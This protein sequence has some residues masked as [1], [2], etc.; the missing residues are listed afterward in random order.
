LTTDVEFCLLG[1]LV[2]RQGGVPV[3]ILPAKLR[4]LLAT[5]L[6][7]ANQPVSLDELAEAMWGSAPPRSS[8]GTLRNHVKSLRKALPEPLSSRIRTQPGGYLFRVQAGELDIDRFYELLSS[9]KADTVNG[10]F[11]RA[12]DQL[13]RCLA[14]WRGEPLA[15]V[16][17]DVLTLRELPRLTEMRL[18]ALAARIDADLQLGKHSDVIGEL[19][20]LTVVHPLRER[21]HALLM[22]ALYRDGQQA[23]ALAAYQNARRV[24]VDELA[25]EP[26]P[27]LRRL[28]RQI[29]AADP[30]LN[31]PALSRRRDLTHHEPRHQ[32][33]RTRPA[34]PRELPAAVRHFTGRRR[35][36]IALTRMSGIAAPSAGGGAMIS[37][38]SG[39]AGVGKTALAVHW[40]HMAAG[41]FP[42]GQ[43]FANLRGYNPTGP[44]SAAEA[45]VGFL[46][47]LGVPGQNIPTELDELAGQFRS[48]VADRR[49]LVVLDNAASV[50]QV[51][52]LLPGGTG[53]VAVITSR[54]SLPGLVAADGAQR[55]N[56][57]PLPL[58]DA[59]QILRALVGDRVID[60]PRAAET[61]A[62]Q[63]ARLPLALRLTA[64]LAAAQPGRR[65]ADLAADLA[66][67][68][69]RLD[70]LNAGGDSR[71]GLRAVF[72]SS[73]QSLDEQTA[74]A[75]RLIGLLPGPDFDAYALA[76]LTG[77]QLDAAQSMLDQL[78]G[79]CLVHPTSHGRFAMHDLLHAYARGLAGIA[80]LAGDSRPDS[81]L[82]RRAAMAALFDYY[83]Y[84]AAVASDALFPS[85]AG[86]RPRVT[87]PASSVPPIAA[88][89]E[90]R[91]WLDAERANLAAAA[92]QMADDGWHSHVTRLAAVLA[93]YLDVGGYYQEA[94]AIHGHASR[95]ASLAGDMSAE[96]DSARNLGIV[97]FRQGRYQRAACFLQRALSLFQALGDVARE[98]RALHDLSLIDL[99][100]GRRYAQATAQLER[101]LSLFRQVGDQSGQARALGNLGLID[102]RQGRYERA[103]HYLREAL[104]LCRSIG[105]R[106]GQARALSNLGVIEERQGRWASA[107]GYLRDALTACREIGDRAGEADILRSLGMIDSR[108]GD[109]VSA[110]RH[111]QHALALST[112]IGERRCQ[113]WALTGLG[114]VNLRQGQLP[115]AIG[116]LQ[117]A[118]ELYR[119]TGN[120]SGEA[121]ACNGLG[122]VLLASGEPEDASLQHLAALSRAE[123]TGE[124]DELARAHYGVARCYREIGKLDQARCHLRQ[125]V[126]KFRDLGAPEVDAARGLLAQLDQDLDQDLDVGPTGTRAA[127]LAASPSLA[128]TSSC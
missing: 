118:L 37:V 100:T 109:H 81:G 27:E 35:E 53:C 97:G 8:R 68:G 39:T 107:C 111:L 17:S 67:E 79:A 3:A 122:E 28:E 76:A 59:I 72:S 19:R 92:A 29:L 41:H 91:A 24:L 123:R 50:E 106:S 127:P 116:L 101:A 86:R 54:D 25:A 94:I 31:A 33:Q 51:R 124:R 16:P 32:E 104:E 58:G 75:F 78:A 66:D 63:C 38:I 82:E 120:E 114:Q 43:L 125:A 61:L 12:A 80:A 83:L 85:E 113:G 52:P 36:F 18:Q 56:V 26:G 110:F 119:A 20:K 34:V 62:A 57:D 6:L 93:R 70:L 5:L 21:F 47:G 22:L 64:E 42:D 103:R 40:A 99:Q 105:D 11:E 46:R 98:A 10:A 14:L 65:L 126:E 73:Y 71:S 115:L 2:V 4:V 9:A 1:P 90:A 108:Q 102:V 55:L 88:P 128:S 89:D 96:A 84:T 74:L 49:V 117:Q 7:N 95:A 23:A 121:E 112:E 87:A 44:V 48:I 30:I 60:D 69:R 77:V 13:C 15:D 45:L